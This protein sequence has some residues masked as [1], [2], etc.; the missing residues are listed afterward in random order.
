MTKERVE[1]LERTIRAAV[2]LL[3]SGQTSRAC[4]ILRRQVKC[5]PPPEIDWPD[6]RAAIAR[7]EGPPDAA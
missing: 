3:E 5:P 4:A 6:S 1:R 7:P 2:W